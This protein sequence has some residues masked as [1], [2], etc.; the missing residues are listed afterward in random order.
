MI[1]IQI[2]DAEPRILLI[3]KMRYSAK[4]PGGVDFIN[5][6]TQEI[7]VEE[8]SAMH[9][10]EQGRFYATLHTNEST[11]ILPDGRKLRMRYETLEDF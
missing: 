9:K 7:Q 2:P 1:Y 11:I 5:L 8:K 4:F 10:I 6:G 3:K